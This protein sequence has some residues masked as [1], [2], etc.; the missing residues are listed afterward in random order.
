MD[1]RTF[2]GSAIAFGATAPAF[3]SQKII[4]PPQ[5]E[6]PFFPYDP[7]AVHD[8]DLVQIRAGE[9]KALGQVVHLFGTARGWSGRPIAGLQ[10]ELWQC[11]ANG[12]YHH[13]ADQE[14]RQP[15][16]RFQGYGKT[17]TDKDGGF[18]FRTIRPV[19]YAAGP[20]LVRTP[21]I[22]IA[23]S[24]K[25]VRRLTTQ[26]YI[27]GEPLNDSDSELAKLLPAQRPALIRPWTDGS[28]IEPGALQAHY[29]LLLI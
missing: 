18:R 16:L 1:R 23:A 25:G 26:L 24:S 5:V 29:D 14:P 17:I 4:T 8:N 12:K 28:S 13:P 10:I 11:D 3:A 21:H 9:A 19:S 2:V 7:P 6:G 22:H 15:D 27:A 20:D